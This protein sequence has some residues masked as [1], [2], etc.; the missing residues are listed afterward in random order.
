MS[1]RLIKDMLAIKLGA[2]GKPAPRGPLGL[3]LGRAVAIEETP[4]ILIDGAIDIPHPGGQCVVIGHGTF[5]VGGVDAHRYYLSGPG[6]ELAGMLQVVERDE[7]RYFRPFD[8]VYPASEAEWA[9]WLDDADGYIGYPSFEAKGAQYQ[10]VWSPGVGRV[11]PLWFEETAVKV[12]GSR[13]TA[14]H[15]AMLYARELAGAVGPVWEYL[16]VTA[17]Q[18]ADGTAWVD[19][20]LGIDLLPS[21]ITAY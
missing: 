20:M 16:L 3:S 12:D 15:T 17:V 18:A 9:F 7:C 6:G 10:R 1:F 14:E 19:L 8:E 13:S 11:A 2:Q 4:F 21:S 5:K